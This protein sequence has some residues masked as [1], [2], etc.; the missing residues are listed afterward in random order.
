MKTFLLRHR[1]QAALLDTGSI[2]VH[3]AP[4]RSAHLPGFRAKKSLSTFRWPISH[5][6]AADKNLSS[7]RPIGL[8]CGGLQFGAGSCVGRV[9]E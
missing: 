1:Q 9:A 5:R 6:A 3:C 2:G 4:S 8:V 7:L